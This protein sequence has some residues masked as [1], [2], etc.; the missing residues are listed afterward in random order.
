[1][2]YRNYWLYGVGFVSILFTG[3][4]KKKQMMESIN[5]LNNYT[6]EGHNNLLYATI[7]PIPFSIITIKSENWKNETWL[8]TNKVPYVVLTHLLDSY[9]CLPERPDMAF[10]FLWKSINNTY[11]NLGTRKRVSTLSK[12]RLSDSD[13]IN[14]LI[15]EI[16]NIKNLPITAHYTVI[17]LIEEY[18]KIIPIKPFKFISNF[19][20][21]G[22]TMENSGILPILRGSSYSSFKKN[23]KDIFDKIKIT[24]G[25]V[26]N[27]ISLPTIVGS[28]CNLNINDLRK[29]N[30]LPKSLAGKLRELL[31]NKASTISASN[32]NQSYTLS[33]SNDKE[34]LTFIIKT[35]LYSIRNNS[36][37]GNIVSRLNSEF[38]SD[39][40]LK[41]AIYIYFLGH[42]ILTLGLYINKEITIEDLS[43]NIRNIELLK[44]II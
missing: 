1:M 3:N 27:G 10:T 41:T 6:K 17:N 35:I 37:H 39:E 15:D 14:Y 25:N 40:S 36:V 13:G 11:K 26:Y 23:H 29:S 24:Y 21:K 9:D 28:E 42:L 30:S 22:N 20:L 18:V 34:Y 16:N 5:L 7:K 32:Q 43:I 33:L 2:R 31:I 12:K 8:L 38:A 19:I 44:T 4:F